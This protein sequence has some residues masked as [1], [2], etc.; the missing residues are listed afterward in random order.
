MSYFR[1]KNRQ[2]RSGSNIHSISS[3]VTFLSFILCNTS[4]D[5]RQ[6]W[7]STS[8]SDYCY[9]IYRDERNEQITK[10]K[11]PLSYFRDE[12]YLIATK[13]KTGRRVGNCNI[14]R[15]SFLMHFDVELCK[16]R[17]C[18]VLVNSTLRW[19]CFLFYKF[20]YMIYFRVIDFEII[21]V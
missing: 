11:C 21:Q 12:E 10:I 6:P 9:R 19:R 2:T 14:Y 17:N 16:A 4:P 8:T 18:G 5:S 7:S 15:D 20:D 13:R 3:N 1:R